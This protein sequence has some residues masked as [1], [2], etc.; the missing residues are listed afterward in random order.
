MLSLD[1]NLRQQFPTAAPADAPFHVMLKPIGPICNLD[2]SYCFYLEK[3]D[4]L[5]PGQSR[6]RM[7]EADLENYVRQYIDA[8]PDDAREISFAFQGGEPTLM[9]L[10]FFQ[11][12]VELQKQYA[13]P[14][15]PIVNALQTNATLLDD[16]WGEFLHEHKFLVGVS[17]DGPEEIHN[18]HRL[19]KA[20][21]GTFDEV[22]R[23]VRVLQKHAVEFNTLTVVHHDNADC[24]TQVY[25]FLK[26]IGST[27][28]QFI[29]IVEHEQLLDAKQYHQRPILPVLQ[30]NGG[31]VR[32]GARS[33]EPR[34]W[35]TFLNGIFDRWL[36]QRDVGRI[37]VQLFDMMLGLVMGY[38][39]SLC[40][41]SKAC[42]RAAAM[43]HNGDVYACDH[44][45]SPEYNL[46]NIRAHSLTEMIDGDQ[47][48]AFGRAK[49]ASLP[50]YCRQ[51]DFLQY[52]WGACPKDRI[53]NTPD[54]EPGLA[55]LCEGYKEFYRHTQPVFRKMALCLKLRQPASAWRD[56]HRILGEGRWGP[57]VGR[58]DPCLCGSGKKFKHCCAK[59]G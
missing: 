29:P 8:Q 26:S 3:Q 13:R 11:R 20:G 37:Y 25:D 21:K 57:R 18:R 44:Y 52:C 33:A 35:G 38:P 12:V 17:I 16:A 19:D 40:V 51:C 55:Y 36:E 42:G 32:V 56:L 1:A 30:P 23:G 58:N 34:Q 28:L 9:G 46:G 4:G 50:R 45:V 15:V 27:F 2:C 48:R 24:P 41:H 10:R 47:Q 14:N 59:P 43:E 49:H 31:G 39:S 6:F 53:R 54:G 7:S 5:F 22:L